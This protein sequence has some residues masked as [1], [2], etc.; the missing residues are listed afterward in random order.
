[1]KHA[2]FIINTGE[3]TA[4]N[5]ENMIAH[6]QATVRASTGVELVRE[7]KIVGEAI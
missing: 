5:I 7:V 1:M 2:N 3:A 6:M 4:A